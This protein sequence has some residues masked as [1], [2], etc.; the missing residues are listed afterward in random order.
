MRTNMKRLLLII[1]LLFCCG[2]ARGDSLLMPVSAA[3]TVDAYGSPNGATER[4]YNY[5]SAIRLKCAELNDGTVYLG[6]FWYTW[7]GMSDSLDAR[8]PSGWVVDSLV[9]SLSSDGS[10]NTTT[11]GES[12]Y[13]SFKPIKPGYTWKE[14]AQNGAAASTDSS[15]NYTYRRWDTASWSGSLGTAFKID[16]IIG[17]GHNDDAGVWH[18]Y[19]WTGSSADSLVRYYEGLAVTADS[20]AA[21]WDINFDSSDGGDKPRRWI[22][23]SA[24]SSSSGLTIGTGTYGT[25]TYGP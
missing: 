10:G 1:A 20:G 12:G 19:T 17:D 23:F 2:Q 13:F 24:S 3:E 15:A 7:L 9:D 21:G 22:Y 14:G 8:F 5:G 6:A 18:K 16:S 25:G 4:T 11:S